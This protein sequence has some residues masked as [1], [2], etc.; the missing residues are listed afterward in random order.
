ML[1]NAAP[2]CNCAE[3]SWQRKPPVSR[4]RLAFRTMFEQR[5]AIK[6][7]SV[8]CR[9]FDGHLFAPALPFAALS[10]LQAHISVTGRAANVHR[11]MPPAAAAACRESG[12][13]ARAACHASHGR[14]PAAPT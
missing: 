8:Q 10:T 5:P 4:R 1:H 6:R 9:P 11:A 12:H 3:K 13:K 14:P 2:L 7:Q